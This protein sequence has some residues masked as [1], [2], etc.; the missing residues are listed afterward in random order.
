M[1][2]TANST[3]EI[4]Y[5]NS[6]RTV[7]FPDEINHIANLLQ[8]IRVIDNALTS[9]RL[10]RNLKAKGHRARATGHF[11]KVHAHDREVLWGMT[12]NTK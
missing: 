3:A 5:S 9:W 1:T 7:T 6:H 11:L 4:G 12:E 10:A 2:T 8:D